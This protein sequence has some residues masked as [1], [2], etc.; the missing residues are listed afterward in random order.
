MV[1]GKGTPSYDYVAGKRR[2]VDRPPV[3]RHRI[4]THFLTV[5]AGIPNVQKTREANPPDKKFAVGVLICWAR[6]EHAFKRDKRLEKSHLKPRERAHESFYGQEH[7]EKV[8]AHHNCP[9]EARP[10]PSDTLHT[11]DLSYT[12]DGA[13]ELPV[14]HAPLLLQL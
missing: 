1:R 8:C 7:P 5:S 10:E 13:L 12:I 14:R 2:E 3:H 9:R 11:H 6:H 4:S